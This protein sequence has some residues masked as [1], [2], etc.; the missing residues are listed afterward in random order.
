MLSIWASQAIQTAPGTTDPG[1]AS[2]VDDAYSDA[3]ISR[4]KSRPQTQHNQ[5]ITLPACRE[6]ITAPIVARSATVNTYR[7]RRVIPPGCRGA[8]GA[9]RCGRA[10]IASY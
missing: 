7:T 1:G 5:P 8:G 4:A 6:T 9:T 10:S 3:N 2:A